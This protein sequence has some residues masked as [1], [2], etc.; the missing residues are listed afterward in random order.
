MFAASDD[1]GGGGEGAAVDAHGAQV[2]GGAAEHDLQP[3]VHATVDAQ[4]ATHTGGADGMSADLA[5]LKASRVSYA[6][7][8]SRQSMARS[9]NHAHYSLTDEDGDRRD[10]KMMLSR[11]SA[12][13]ASRSRR[14]SPSHRERFARTR[15][16]R[17]ARTARRMIP[18]N[19]WR[20]WASAAEGRG[21]PT[22]VLS[23]PSA[24]GGGAGPAP[25][26]SSCSVLLGGGSAAGATW[27]GG[28][29]ATVGGGR[30]ASAAAGA[31][32]ARRARRQ[33]ASDAEGC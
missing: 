5:A 18:S 21:S 19:R 6:A 7:W 26:R 29:D 1:D 13:R 3:V 4:V 11:P 23:P 9:Y 10:L 15:K 16:R 22:P 20:T 32:A 25:P 14:V 2:D 24:G 27:L 28:A 30:G 31:A 33:R 17:R 12:A 8:P